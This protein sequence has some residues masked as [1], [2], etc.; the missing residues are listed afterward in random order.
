[1][2][3][4]KQINVVNYLADF[5]AKFVQS[6]KQLFDHLCQVDLHIVVHAF[7]VFDSYSW[8]FTLAFM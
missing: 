2:N 4:S 5:F 7:E 8:L 6:D 1:M 3:C